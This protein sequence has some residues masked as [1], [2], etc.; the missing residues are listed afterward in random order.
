MDSKSETVMS[1]HG[2]HVLKLEYLT[3]MSAESKRSQNQTMWSIPF[4]LHV[5]VAL[6]IHQVRGIMPYP[7]SLECVR[8]LLFGGSHT[9]YILR[10]VQFILIVKPIL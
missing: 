7:M 3:G 1:S 4:N 2:F 8:F 5:D 9:S 6:T 10:S